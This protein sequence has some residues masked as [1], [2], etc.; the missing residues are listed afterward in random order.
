VKSLLLW[1]FCIVLFSYS[2]AQCPQGSIS[3]SQELVLNSNF[4]SGNTGFSSSYTY[5]SGSV[6][7]EGQY[8]INTNARNV[9]P[10][11]RGTDHTTGSGNFMIINGAPMANTPVWCQTINVHPNTVY[12]FSAWVSSMVISNPA[13]LQF[14]INGNNL[15]TTFNAPPVIN[16]WSQFFISWNSGTDTLANICVVN[17]N[18]IS[19]G[20]DFALD[21]ISFT[22]CTCALIADAGS[23]KNICP[24]DSIT[25]VA[26]P[27]SFNYLWSTGDTS[28]FLVVDTP[29]IYFLITSS[30]FCADSDTVSISALESPVVMITGDSL[31]CNGSPAVM[32][33]GQGF[34][35]YI[36]SSGDSMQV[37]TIHIPGH[38]F[39]T[40]TDSSGC[41]G[42]DSINVMMQYIQL[43]VILGDTVFCYGDSALLDAGTG[44]ESYIWS[45]GDSAQVI[46][47]D[48][49]G[50]Y[51]VTVMDSGCI[52]T[53]SI[54]I[55]RR[56]PNFPVITGDTVFCENDSSL[57]FVNGIFQSYHWNTGLTGPSI[58]VDRAGTFSVTTTDKDGCISSDSVRVVVNS[59]PNINYS[60]EKGC[61]GLDMT[62]I[63]NES[64]DDIISW[65]FGDGSNV[66]NSFKVIHHYNF[67]G[68][69][70]IFLEALSP[71]GCKSDSLFQVS[72]DTL[73]DVH[74]EITQSTN[75]ILTGDPVHFYTNQTGQNT[76]EWNFGDGNFSIQ[77]DPVYNYSIPGNYSV[78]LTVTSPDGCKA[79][80]ISNIEA[81]AIYI[82][83]SFTPNG[84]GL[85]DN[86]SVSITNNI[87]DYSLEI[88]NRQGKK[89]FKSGSTASIWDGNING[90]PAPNGVYEYLVEIK[91]DSGVIFHKVGKV[92]LIR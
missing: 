68:M 74:A 36:W 42:T 8:A 33:A 13:T 78:M 39:V 24:G 76:F 91:D 37:D 27:P 62:F 59:N 16:I 47:A 88:F 34:A 79:I 31:I 92:T 30:S 75:R 66:N 48:T 32:D 6:V 85:N 11:F 19:F 35:N 82:A 83:N 84:D 71:L 3:S 53:D 56:Q 72:I 64:N 12:L 50:T 87:Y 26:N 41:R 81:A 5:Y 51:F 10:D 29:G 89:I 60:T 40:V 70:N 15:G 54:K 52:A 23:D 86:F 45:I 67:P 73:S 90:N 9:H 1:L 28:Q 38:Y 25:L 7:N 17:Q 61:H 18:T 65:N 14:S 22:E 77:E 43:P 44:F 21:D 46:Y 20:N 58:I 63:F 4:S 49:S 55:K 57:L 69:Y 80:A 2:K